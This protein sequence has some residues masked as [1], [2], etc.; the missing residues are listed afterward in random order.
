MT[1]TVKLANPPAPVT[2]PD[3]YTFTQRQSQ[4]TMLVCRGLSN[5]AIAE[6]LDLAERTVKAHLG[7]LYSRLGFPLATRNKRILLAQAV[8]GGE[9]G[10][11][12]INIPVL[13][14]RQRRLI[15]EITEARSNREIAVTL[16]TTEQVVKN[17]LRD[18]YDKTG[19]SNRLE[20]TLWSIRSDIRHSEQ[21]ADVA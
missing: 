5:S 18:V 15:S 16:G 4:I 13:T 1:F 8:M 12:D 21:A 20:L 14:P 6:T 19:S 10:T 7:S 9:R 11:S 17:Y 3:S 2:P